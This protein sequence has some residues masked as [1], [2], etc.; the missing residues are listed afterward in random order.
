MK[1]IKTLSA[2]CLILLMTCSF[3]T[4]CSNVDNTPNPSPVQVVNPL[5]AVSSV[6]EMEDY[7][8]FT[9]PVLDKEVDSYIV[10]VIDGYPSMGRIQYADD[11][12]FSIQYGT[13]DISGIYGGTLEKT[14]P[15]NGV[16]VSYYTYE[17]IRYAL[18]ETGGF[19]HSLTG[20]ITLENDVA[21]LIP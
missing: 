18:W 20:G 6:Q 3:M 13:G 2:L 12:L 9:I 8:D 15:V 14:E 19:T 5:R 7:L 4:G 11:S 17:T 10:L 1:D 21:A 16:K